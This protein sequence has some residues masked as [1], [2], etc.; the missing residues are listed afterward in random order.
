MTPF[1]ELTRH[2]EAWMRWRRIRRGLTWGLRGLSLGLF[3]SLLWGMA[4]VLQGWFL[5]AEFIA[6]SIALTLI[7]TLFA[8]WG[9]AL[10]PLARLQSA[11]DFDRAFHL[12]ERVSTALELH[13]NP[14]LAPPELRQRQ[15][16][17]ALT[18][19]RRVNPRRDLPLRLKPLEVLLPLALAGALFIGYVQSERVFQATNQA[20][21]VEQ[22]VQ[23]QTKAIEEL[24]KQVQANPA[25]T[26]EQKKALAAPL[27]QAL[28]ELQQAP[29]Q[30]R[31]VSVLLK[32]NEQVQALTE[33]QA[34]KT[35]QALQQAGQSLANQEGT[36][37]QTVAQRLAESNLVSAATELLKI[38]PQTLSAEE[39]AQMAQQ[40]QQL[41]QAVQGSNPQLA[42]Q[43]NQAAQALQNGNPAAAQQ[44]LQQAAQS[45]A[46]LGQQQ[47]ISQAA[48]QAA[49]QLQQA[50]GQILTAGGS[51]L[52][53][54]T[55]DSPR[56]GA[57]GSTGGSSGKG[58]SEN[59]NAQGGEVL[60]SSDLPQNQP[61]DGGETTYEQIYAPSLLGGE[62]G[63][64]V[65]VNS[66]NRQ[67]GEVI[68]Q[69]PS[70]PGQDGQSLV[71]YTQ[72][73][74]QYEERNRR[75]IESGQIPLQFRQI[76]R[77]YFDSLKP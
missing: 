68:G 62:S 2:L 39:A 4:G 45:L 43:L 70:T 31:A 47:A 13:A 32:S 38:N 29:G 65:G 54:Q 48:A 61:G 40:L 30:E 63:P 51:N 33:P 24:L 53:E 21:A 44:A 25:L 22:A 28:Q 7:V 5:Q 71:P 50:A 1:D 69:L 16:E 64:Q 37:V 6:F 49:A 74:A 36:P 52:P 57:Q 35:I 73:L 56:A 76:I 72:V 75:A 41:A 14:N 46:Q 60:S 20:R 8:G 55:A 27:E 42:Q 19:A 26:E 77:N 15:L 67:D 66:G 17:D 34:E 10:W 59:P 58:T 9:A 18:A 11:R 3:L 12:R 23:E